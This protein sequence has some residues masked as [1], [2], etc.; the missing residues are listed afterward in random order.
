M[1]QVAHHP[2]FL[3]VSSLLRQQQQ[4]QC[5][6]SLSNT[7]V[8]L[9]AS[10]NLSDLVFLTA[11]RKVPKWGKDLA[12]YSI[13]VPPKQEICWEKVNVSCAINYKLLH[14]RY[15]EDQTLSGVLWGKMW[16]LQFAICN[17]QSEKLL[18][19]NITDWNDGWFSGN[20]TALNALRFVYHSTL[21]PAKTKIELKGEIGDWPSVI[22]D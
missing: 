7:M 8:I 2:F 15:F 6:Y 4:S 3:F 12:Y 10:P 13:V 19:Y 1:F 11:Y 18:V 21:A 17:L 16:D 5:V 22:S 9:T 14:M 20:Q